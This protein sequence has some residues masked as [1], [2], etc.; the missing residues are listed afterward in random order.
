MISLN[1]AI[2]KKLFKNTLV[3]QIL[4]AVMAV[5]GMVLNNALTGIFLGNTSLVALGS[6][7]P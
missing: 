4:A 7:N 3:V 2:V 6:R 1:D 5:L